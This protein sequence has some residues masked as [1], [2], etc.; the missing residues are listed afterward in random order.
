MEALT[1]RSSISTNL[2]DHA[3]RSASRNRGYSFDAMVLSEAG[4]TLLH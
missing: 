3:P 4:S 1:K 2:G